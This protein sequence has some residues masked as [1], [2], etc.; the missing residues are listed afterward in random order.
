VWL[1]IG[2]DGQLVEQRGLLERR[3]LVEQ[4]GLQLVEQHGLQLVEQHGLQ[5]VEQH[6]LLEQ[7]QL[8]ERVQRL[9][10]RSRQVRQLHLRPVIAPRRG[11]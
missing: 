10:L 8:F 1:R 7:L 11:S 5:L 6:G 2:D 4:H 9:R 3:R